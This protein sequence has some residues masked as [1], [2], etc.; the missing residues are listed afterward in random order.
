MV[1][2]RRPHHY[3]HAL[4]RRWLTP[5]YDPLMRLTMRESVFKPMLVRQAGI[6]PGE[7]VLDLGCGTATLTILIKQTYPEAR[8]V[9][10]D[11]DAGVLEIARAK[12]AAAGAAIH[13]DLGMAYALPYSDGAFDHVVSSLVLHHLTRA[14]KQQTMREVFRVLRPG[15]GLHVVDFGPP[16]SRP[17]RLAAAI[18]RRLEETAD[19]F[20]GLLPGMFAE[21]GFAMVEEAAQFAT[22]FGPLSLYRAQKPAS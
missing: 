15:G 16:R 22:L 13:L 20:D 18:M 19:N 14:D 5:L 17:M 4:N 2:E 11:G 3:I 7:S 10:L 21:A 8:V 12:A 9:G 1:H 6:Q